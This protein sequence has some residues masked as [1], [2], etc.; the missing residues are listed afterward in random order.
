M[1]NESQY[2]VSQAVPYSQEAEEA[3]IGAVLVNPETYLT[4]ASFLKTEDFFLLR[5]AYVWQALQRL[6]NRNEPID[7]VTLTNEVK[8]MGRLEEIGGQAYITYLINSTPTSIYAEIY[9]RLVER[10]AIRRRLLVAA[11]EIRGL[12]LNE[13]LTID[14]VTVEAETRLFAVTDRQLKREFVPM[15]DAVNEYFDRIEHPI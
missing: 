15:R 14:A 1:T 6:S 11:D 5:N 4:V 9:G 10:A 3:V 13:E 8:D 7:L 12:A 2:L